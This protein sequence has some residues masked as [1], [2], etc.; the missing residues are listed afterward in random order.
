MGVGGGNVSPD[1]ILSSDWSAV[2]SVP[3]TALEV[4]QSLPS[5]QKWA[6][7]QTTTLWSTTQPWPASLPSFHL[8]S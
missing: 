2:S 1:W 4:H 7:S 8:L 3:G 6:G 5:L